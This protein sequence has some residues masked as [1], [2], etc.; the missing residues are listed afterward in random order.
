MPAFGDEIAA[1]NDSPEQVEADDGII[2]AFCENKDP[3][4]ITEPEVPSLAVNDEFDDVEMID[5]HESAASDSSRI[6]SSILNEQF[7]R[8]L[9]RL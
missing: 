3:I 7:L 5:E 4:K 2:D 9:R 1:Y 8:Q 6:K